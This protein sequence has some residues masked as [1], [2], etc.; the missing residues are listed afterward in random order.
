MTRLTNSPS[1]ARVG[2]RYRL[3][4]NRTVTVVHN[5]VATTIAKL[6]MPICVRR[7]SEATAPTRR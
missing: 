7:I 1:P 3:P 4:N 5:L 2:A 6:V